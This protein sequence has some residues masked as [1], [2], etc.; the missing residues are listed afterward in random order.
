[1]H[2]EAAYGDFHF[3]G[4]ISNERQFIAFCRR[5]GTATFVNMNKPMP[6]GGAEALKELY[7]MIQGCGGE[8]CCCGAGV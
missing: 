5:C 2:P 8:C 6:T 7:E 1:M 4:F 3:L